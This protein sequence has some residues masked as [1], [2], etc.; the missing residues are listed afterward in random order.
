MK[1]ARTF[2]LAL[3]A[4]LILGARCSGSGS[5]HDLTTT[6]DLRFRTDVETPVPAIP[7]P[8]SLLLFAV[9][10]VVVAAGLRRRRWSPR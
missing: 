10:G 7:E 8:T 1:I 5:D 9:G 2:A 3:V 4:G 6:A